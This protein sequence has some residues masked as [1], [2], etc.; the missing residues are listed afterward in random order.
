MIMFRAAVSQSERSLMLLAAA[1]SPPLAGCIP[2]GSVECDK[3]GHRRHRQLEAFSPCVRLRFLTFLTTI[4]YVSVIYL[5][6][7][8]IHSLFA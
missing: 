5:V 2:S 7:L 1:V 6:T 3:S 8:A 4:E